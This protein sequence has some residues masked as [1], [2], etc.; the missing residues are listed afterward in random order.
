M[1]QKP[2]SII[3]I[4]L[5]STI[6]FSPIISPISIISK[7]HDVSDSLSNNFTN[8]YPLTEKIQT[9]LNEVNEET[10][11][12]FLT[13]LVSFSPRYT[14]TSG[15]EQAASYI[16][17]QFTQNG[18]QARYQSW[19]S[20]GNRYHPK[21]FTS[22]NVE[23]THPGTDTDNIILFGAHY[24][25]VQ[26]VPGANDD[27][28][29]TAAVLAAAYILSKYSFRHTLKFV[30]FS[31]EEIG[32]KGS[33]AYADEAYQHNDNIL[34][35][36]NADMIG[37]ATTIEGGRRMGFSISEDATWIMDILQSI[38]TSQH[39]QT[40]LSQSTIDR[41]G[42]GHSDYFPFA[43][44]GWES[45]ACW[46]GEHDPNMHT[47]QDDL[48]NINF[49][50][51]VKT[52]KFIVG[53][54]AYLADET[55]IYPQ[56]Q[57]EKPKRHTIYNNGMKIGTAS[58]VKSV[59]IDDISIFAA[60]NHK[61]MYQIDR[62]EF[63]FDDILEFTDTNPPFRW[64]CDVKGIGNHRITIISYDHIGQKTIDYLDIFYINL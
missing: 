39:L 35:M 40:T 22:E 12:E 3:I 1:I 42:T 30:T 60:N 57:I 64:Y 43:A 16:F 34:F 31:G 53:T 29:G 18:L 6:I 20:F 62:V 51:L 19:S 9:I 7:D 10:L 63:Y 8:S 36:I 46:Q 56:I 45:I 27:G 44:Y 61:D 5:L 23:G 32:L 24:D 49:S 14:G 54:L 55:D 13:N 15:C 52:T 26:Q 50:Y 33:W 17:D 37:R 11:E 25:T 38:N 4:F 59:I 47:E 41:D 58:N 48:S 28:S 21:Y 2:L